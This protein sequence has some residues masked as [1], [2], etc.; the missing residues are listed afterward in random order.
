MA[1]PIHGSIFDS[2]QEHHRLLLMILQLSSF[3]NQKNHAVA[4]GWHNSHGFPACF[5]DF[6]MVQFPLLLSIDHVFHRDNGMGMSPGIPMW[7][8]RDLVKVPAFFEALGASAKIRSPWNCWMISAACCSMD[9]SHRASGSHGDHKWT[10]TRARWGLEKCGQLMF[11][12]R[13]IVKP[14]RQNMTKRWFGCV[15]SPSQ[16]AGEW[17]RTAFHLHFLRNIQLG[18]YPPMRPPSAVLDHLQP[19]M[20]PWQIQALGERLMSQTQWYSIIGID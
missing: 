12:S 6:A 10:T 18:S 9:R 17:L 8:H 7:N 20:N 11:F 19:G 13:K 2:P 5:P 4:W 3:I 16:L 15:P 1:S 14:L